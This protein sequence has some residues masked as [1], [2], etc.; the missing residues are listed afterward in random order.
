MPPAVNLACARPRVSEARGRQR[1]KLG[2][3]RHL[4]LDL[5]CLQLSCL[6]CLRDRRRSRKVS[7]RRSAAPRVK[8]RG[9]RLKLKDS[10]A[11]QALQ[12]SFCPTGSVSTCEKRRRLTVAQP[13]RPFG[14]RLAF[15]PSCRARTGSFCNSLGQSGCLHESILSVPAQRPWTLRLLSGQFQR[16]Q[17]HTIESSFCPMLSAFTCL[18]ER[19]FTQDN[20]ESA[21]SKPA[22][23]HTVRPD[24]CQ[25]SLGLQICLA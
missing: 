1:E 2:L 11:L 4:L 16:T 10:G 7:Q 19:S 5:L 24:G 25:H 23:C 14:S 9:K 21:Q 15:N 17:I 6:K 18:K 8:R 20:T 12:S 13:K 3:H 22:A